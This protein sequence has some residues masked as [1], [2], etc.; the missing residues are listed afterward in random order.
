ME[1]YEL[2]ILEMPKVVSVVT[3]IMSWYL[4]LS[5]EGAGPQWRES[6]YQ[7]HLS[8]SFF[9]FCAYFHYTDITEFQTPDEALDNVEHKQTSYP[10]CTIEYKGPIIFAL[11]FWVLEPAV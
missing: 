9:L 4:V 8:S 11:R 10:Y 3:F 7:S 2:G 6:K 5:E 1:V